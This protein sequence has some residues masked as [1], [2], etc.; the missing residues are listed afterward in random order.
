MTSTCQNVS[1][2]KKQGRPARGR[3]AHIKKIGYEKPLSLGS[4]DLL[5]CVLLLAVHREI[6]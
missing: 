3:P 4:I 6:S 5:F 1:R 2:V